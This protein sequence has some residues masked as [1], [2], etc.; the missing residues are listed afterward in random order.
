M[1][2]I[3]NNPVPL[4]PPPP[5]PTTFDLIGLTEGEV[6]V[7]RAALGNM[8]PADYVARNTDPL[9]ACVVSRHLRDTGITYTHAI[10][11]RQV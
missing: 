3:V 5:P 9:K 11:R 6:R 4:P 2:V 10:T 1:K 7:L 8:I